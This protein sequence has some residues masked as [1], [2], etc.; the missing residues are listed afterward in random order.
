MGLTKLIIGSVAALWG[1][2]GVTKSLFLPSK[3]IQ[4]NSIIVHNEMS[5]SLDVALGADF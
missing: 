3:I 5:N 2:D 4:L 1:Q